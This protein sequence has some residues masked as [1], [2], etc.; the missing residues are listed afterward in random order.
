MRF[1][2]K[3]IIFYLFR[4]FSLKSIH[5]F[6][7][8]SLFGKNKPKRYNLVI[9]YKIIGQKDKNTR[10]KFASC[11]LCLQ[12]NVVNPPC[13]QS[14]L[15]LSRFTLHLSQFTLHLSQFTLHLSQFTISPSLSH[16]ASNAIHLAS[17]TSPPYKIHTYKKQRPRNSPQPLLNFI[18][19]RLPAT[20]RY[21]HYA[22]HAQT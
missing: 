4:I 20:C 8:F 21:T 15:R 10:W 3:H 16:P 2:Q 17:I 18:S 22:S 7:G 9:L 11:L 1:S 14:T 5:K 12:M 19:C 13:I 6:R